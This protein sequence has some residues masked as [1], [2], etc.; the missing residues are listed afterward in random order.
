MVASHR[1]L[2]GAGGREPLRAAALP[3]D[4]A[5]AARARAA[6]LQAGP[7]ETVVHGTAAATAA[8]SGGGTG[9]SGAAVRVAAA[10]AA[11]AGFL[12][13]PEETAV[14]PSGAAGFDG[15]FGRGGLARAA[16]HEVA[17]EA[18]RDGAAAAGLVVALLARAAAL[19]V[20]GGVLWAGDGLAL[21]EGG[22]GLYGPGLRDLGFDP[23]R[24]VLVEA[25]KL[26]DVLWALEEGLGSGALSAVV[27][28]VRGSPAGLDLTATRRLM[29]RARETG[30]TAVLIRL[31]AVAAPSA[32]ATRIR[33]A[34]Y[35]SAG[36]LG[37][38]RPAWTLR[39]EK[40]R[41]GPVG[42]AVVEWDPDER[43]FR[44]LSRREI[45]RREPPP[46]GRAAHPGG[47]AAAPAD[48]PAGAAAAGRPAVG[49]RR[50]G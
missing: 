40:N 37:P 50:V 46:G 44:E 42:S 43:S 2:G 27:G 1:P 4:D 32:A 5:A 8:A 12:A 26:A 10:R 25:G 48:R 11:V 35:R 38:G 20:D 33:V 23:A 6:R 15:L 3:P 9:G 31:S 47:L 14:L 30:R 45:A 39:V 18:A 21:R 13:E 22:G 29:L 34:P 19:G 16:L 24:L 36:H 49:E 28:E 17:A 7:G 41:E